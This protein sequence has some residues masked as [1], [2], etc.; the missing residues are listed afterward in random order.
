ML[1]ER[2]LWVGAT[3][4]AIG[5]L[6]LMILQLPPERRGRAMPRFDDPGAAARSDLACRPPDDGWL[7]I[8]LFYVGGTPTLV[9]VYTGPQSVGRHPAVR[10]A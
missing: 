3:S 10:C 8:P 9:R 6:L 2:N 4:V 1:T 5:I 7:D